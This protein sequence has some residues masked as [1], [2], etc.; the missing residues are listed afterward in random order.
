MIEE[1]LVTIVFQL[2]SPEMVLICRF[3]QLIG[4]R[5]YDAMLNF[6]NWRA[7]GYLRV[8]ATLMRWQGSV[9]G[10]LG[11][12][13]R[14]DFTSRRGRARDAE[15]PPASRMAASSCAQIESLTRAYERPALR[16]PFAAFPADSKVA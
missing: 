9:S 2:Q 6:S 8:P 7:P 12:L 10:L 16:K 5:G 13:E 15:K 1:P 4:S 11:I 3:G 14:V